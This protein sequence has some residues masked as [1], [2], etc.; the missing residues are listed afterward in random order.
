MLSSTYVAFA[1]ISSSAL[2]SS[3]PTG[4][5]VTLTSSIFMTSEVDITISTS[6]TES[7]TSSHTNPTQ[8]VVYTS[9][10]GTTTPTSTVVYGTSGEMKTKNLT[11]DYTS[12]ATLT[13]TLST[14]IRQVLLR[15]AATPL[16]SIS[17]FFKATPT[18][19]EPNPRYIRSLYVDVSA[20]NFTS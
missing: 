16:Y 8:T 15:Q 3:S 7:T 4:D 10:E 1:G 9:S 2:F 6:T 18:S 14:S 17:M 13:Q 5:S 12:S 19:T 20:T 11:L